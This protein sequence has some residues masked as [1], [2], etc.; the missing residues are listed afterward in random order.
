MF[1][2]EGYPPTHSSNNTFSLNY[3][4]DQA[5]ASE[6][7]VF[8]YAPRLQYRYTDLTDI[9]SHCQHATSSTTLLET[10]A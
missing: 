2:P 9:A 10:A 6:K 5:E 8:C 4:H 3:D 1:G 7:A